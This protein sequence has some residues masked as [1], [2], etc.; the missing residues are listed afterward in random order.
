MSYESAMQWLKDL[1]LNN[2]PIDFTKFTDEQLLKTSITV[3]LISIDEA[4]D[5]QLELEKRHLI[6][7]YSSMRK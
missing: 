6:E 2:E 3:D 4:K 5:F 1:N 7:K